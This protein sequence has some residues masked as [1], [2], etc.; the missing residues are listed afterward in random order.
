M[1]RR[2]YF[3]INDYADYT[4]NIAVVTEY[5]LGRIVK[6]RKKRNYGR[7]KNGAVSYFA[8]PIKSLR[9]YHI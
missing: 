4:G 2:V 9:S 3:L 7:M 6:L 1:H 8:V 5:S